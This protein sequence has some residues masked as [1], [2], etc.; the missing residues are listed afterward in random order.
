MAS[1]AQQFLKDV[2]KK[3]WMEADKSTVNLIIKMLEPFKGQVFAPA[4]NVTRMEK[5]RSAETL[6]TQSCC[7]NISSAL[8]ASPRFKILLTGGCA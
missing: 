5:D 4:M 1:E 3:L 8:S 6:G 2:D 7:P